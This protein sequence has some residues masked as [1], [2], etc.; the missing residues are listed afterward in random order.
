M[1]NSLRIMAVV[2]KRLYDENVSLRA[3]IIRKT[4]EADELRRMLH[5][6]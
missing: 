4:Q 2:L 6:K 1:K 5:G 3:E